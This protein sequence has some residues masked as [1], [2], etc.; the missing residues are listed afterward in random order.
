MAIIGGG[1]GGL[2]TALKLRRQG[3]SVTIFEKYNQLGGMMMYGILII[4]CPVMCYLMRLTV[5]SIQVLKLE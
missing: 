2:T 1:C 4:V 5:L 3:H